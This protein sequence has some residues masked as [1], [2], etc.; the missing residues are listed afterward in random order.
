[1]YNT[2]DTL[3]NN[4]LKFKYA[5]KK[6]RFGNFKVKNALKMDDSLGVLRLSLGVLSTPLG[7]PLL[8][9]CYTIGYKRRFYNDT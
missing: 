2:T 3:S 1:M 5:L 9:I 7:T 4:T 8:V 6:R